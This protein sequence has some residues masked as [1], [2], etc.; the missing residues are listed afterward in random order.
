MGYQFGL[1]KH[2]LQN[3]VVMQVGMPSK[4]SSLLTGK[5]LWLHFEA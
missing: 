1:Q 5:M 3:L 4:M 2:S